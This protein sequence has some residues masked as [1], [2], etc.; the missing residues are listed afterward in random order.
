MRLRP[1]R[2]PSSC[3]VVAEISV[4]LADLSRLPA[5]RA[6][7][8]HAGPEWVDGAGDG[9][10]SVQVALPIPPPASLSSIVGR[11]VYLWPDEQGLVLE[12]A[13]S[14]S[15][16]EAAIPAEFRRI[17]LPEFIEPQVARDPRLVLAHF[18]PAMF[19]ALFDSTRSFEP[20]TRDPFRRSHAELM[21]EHFEPLPQLIEGLLP[22]EGL[23]V[24]AGKPK[25]GK[26]WLG[27]Q[28]AV[29]IASGAPFLGRKVE[30]GGVLALFLEDSMRR[31]RDRL[32]LQRADPVLPIS[33][34]TRFDKLD[35][36][37][38]AA[39]ERVISANG[40][41][42][43]I[44]DTVA[45]ATSGKFDENEAAVAGAIFNPLRELAQDR[46]VLILALM[47][48]GK[49]SRGDAVLDVRGS[50]AVPGAADAI[51]GLYQEENGHVLRVTGRDLE[52]Q[53][54]RVAFDVGRTFAW[55]L[56]GDARDLARTEA[57][58]ECVA[59]LDALGGSA[60]AA[61]IAHAVGKDRATVQKHVKRMFEEGRLGRRVDG[62]KLVY[63]RPAGGPAAPSL[64]A[65]T[66]TTPGTAQESAPI[67][68][69]AQGTLPMKKSA[70]GG[71]NG[72]AVRGVRRGRGCAEGC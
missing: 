39:L 14:L 63:F 17:S 9:F 12:V 47:H 19:L 66:P 23:A 2:A 56:V 60:D 33:Y 31:L 59:A 68:Q 46:H 45:S 55:Q 16:L 29:S 8:L 70:N 40:I 52:A 71:G 5:G 20:A 44:I 69:G 11:T 50:S 10:V 32:E 58:A 65:C 42:L 7:L 57:E 37:G 24:L 6:V 72:A 4:R 49:G 18:G 64:P 36:G 41:K 25:L 28:L 53:E 51:L 22:N 26:S 21:R 1:L 3:L 54:L 30:Q 35:Q 48:H 62:P 13:R 67:D 34:V 27:L 38:L 61:G 15:T 43:L